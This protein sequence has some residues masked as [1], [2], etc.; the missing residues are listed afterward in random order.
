MLPA[1]KKVGTSI[2]MALFYVQI[3]RASNERDNAGDD[4][5]GEGGSRGYDETGE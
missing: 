4:G 3:V 2:L 1:K 5:E